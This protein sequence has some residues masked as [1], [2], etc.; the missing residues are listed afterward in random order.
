M[1]TTQSHLSFLLSI[2][3]CCELCLSAK[4]FEKNKPVSPSDQINLF[5]DKCLSFLESY[6]KYFENYTTV[7]TVQDP[8]EN[9]K[10]YLTCVL[11][12]TNSY[13]QAHLAT[14]VLEEDKKTKVWSITIKNTKFKTATFSMLRYDQNDV[15]GFMPQLQNLLYHAMR[16][17]NF[18]DRNH[19]NFNTIATVLTRIKEKLPV[20]YGVELTPLIV[21]DQNPGIFS[22][23][24]TSK[25]TIL[26]QIDIWLEPTDKQEFL[27]DME[28]SMNHVIKITFSNMANE[29]QN[30]VVEDIPVICER[31]FYLKSPVD[32]IIAHLD[33]ERLFNNLS[34]LTDRVK[35]FLSKSMS[36]LIINE[37]DKST[38][39]I[40]PAFH[41][42]RF[43]LGDKKKPDTLELRIAV[44]IE[45][46]NSF[47]YIAVDQ[48][49]SEFKNPIY[50]L[51]FTRMGQSALE[52]YLTQYR[53]DKL[54]KTTYEDISFMVEDEYTRV[55]SEYKGLR[56]AQ[57]TELALKDKMPLKEFKVDFGPLSKTKVV[58]GFFNDEIVGL[59]NSDIEFTYSADKKHYVTMNLSSKS[60]HNSYKEF[61]N[62]DKYK[63]MSLQR[64]IHHFFQRFET[65]PGTYI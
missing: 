56:E 1:R 58:G 28:L 4:K 63:H 36:F 37:L 15:D 2:L 64:I 20:S 27:S 45:L 52:A 51:R 62:T 34:D 11:N 48:K 33:V 18:W 40:Q 23:Q 5:N 3:L 13:D 46:G 17:S 41:F 59:K 25:E 29:K 54:F 19:L 53:L 8:D 42:R 57:K 30:S 50:S 22:Y 60:R 55:L 10:N 39:I 65:D 44:N 16:L 47:F 61:F 21:E 31:E 12:M 49:G 14:I 24:F 6:Q 7:P 35:K 32:R 43:G 26:G 38:Q 9:T